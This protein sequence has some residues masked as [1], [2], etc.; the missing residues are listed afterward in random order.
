[1]TCLYIKHSAVPTL[2]SLPSTLTGDFRLTSYITIF[3]KITQR[4]QICKIPKHELGYFKEDTYFSSSFAF[5]KH[6]HFADNI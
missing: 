4:L 2:T 6:I 3:L 1:M 5:N